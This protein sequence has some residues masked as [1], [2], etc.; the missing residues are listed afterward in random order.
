MKLSRRSFL[1]FAIGGAAGTALTPLPWKLT[2]DL[3]I[4]SQNWPWTPVPADGEYKYV[5]STCT[6]CPGNCGILVRKVDDRAV[7][8]EGRQDVTAGGGLCPLG[9]SGLQFLYGPT[10]IQAPLKRVGDRGA[11][12]F[13][14]ITWK[15]ATA[16]VAAKLTEI[17]AQGNPQS[18]ACLVP[19][20]VG[21][22]PRLFQRL[23]TAYG[24]PNFIRMPSVDDAYQ[25]TL[26]LT[27]G[28]EGTLGLDVENADFILSFG[29]AL[30]DGY[31]SPVRMIRAVTRLK[32][33]K[34]TLVQVEPRLSNTVA[35]ADTWL[36]VKP[37]TE[38][39]LALGM[40]YVIIAR[41]RFDAGYISRHVKGFNEFAGM[42][43]QNYTPEKVADTTGI[44]A[45]VIA[46][47]A[48]AFADAK[49]P[50]ALYGRGKGQIAGSLKEALAVQALNAL[51]GNIDQEGGVIGLPA[52]DYIDWPEVTPDAIAHTGLRTPRLDDAGTDRFPHARYLVHRFIEKLHAAPV[53]LQVL[54]VGETN[55]IQNLPDAAGVKTA[56]DKIPFVVSFS[57]FMDETAMQ[58]DLILPNHVYLERYE[59]VPT[60]ANATRAAIGLT[61]PV[62]KPLYQTRHLG[63]SIIQI[64][65]AMP[66][67][68]ADAFE[69]RDYETCLRETLGDRWSS[70]HRNGYWVEREP[71]NNGNPFVLMNDTLRAIYMAESPSAAGDATYPLLLVP[72]DSIRLSSGYAGVPPFMM[73]SL[74]DTTLK[75]QDGFVEI[76]PDTAAGLGLRQDQKVLLTTPVGQA[77]VRVN[78]HD[79]AMPGIV[80]MPRGLG[81]TAYDG[82]MAGKGVNINHLI[83][84]VQD[85]A[86]GLDAVW[87]IR[88]KLTKV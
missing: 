33:R 57:S 56:F 42:L 35:K 18:V 38:A 1:S 65:R 12:H 74:E 43:K 46:R 69:W 16:E 21:T 34:G 32:E 19:T 64:A 8:I 71:D 85:P 82:Y 5:H 61:Q 4:W 24:S 70:M 39:D 68:V 6:L 20:D 31:G 45:D 44:D 60:K 55:P 13:R 22:V 52:Q 83:G 14:T 81:H 48:L 36:A 88:A 84:S 49:R 50:L 29:S 54:L 63:D 75:G 10:R 47:T 25:A 73:K 2:D 77:Q 23:L 30:M 72:Y 79:G 80:A 15:Q 58:S 51:V 26:R 67:P 78:L 37:G 86:S 17:R 62:V 76:N 9:L 3:A 28:I 27:Q 11:G 53:P 87:G 59:D 40:A 41:Q 7:K 66:G